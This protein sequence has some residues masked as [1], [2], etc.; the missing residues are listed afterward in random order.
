MCQQYECTIP[1]QFKVEYVRK[2]SLFL[3]KLQVLGK[4]FIQVSYKSEGCK[5]RSLNSILRNN[6]V[7]NAN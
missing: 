6:S 2:T 7:I 4:P 1:H 5:R 3:C